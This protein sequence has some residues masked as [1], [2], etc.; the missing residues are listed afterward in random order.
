MNSDEISK[1]MAE[2]DELE[3]QS[4]REVRRQE[5]QVMYRQLAAQHP[6]P[7]PPP[8][9]VDEPP[10]D[11]PPMA[12]PPMDEQMEDPPVEDQPMDDGQM[13]RLQLTEDHL[14]LRRPGWRDGDDIGDKYWPIGEL[15]ELRQEALRGWW[16]RCQEPKRQ[17][18]FELF[19]R[20]HKRDVLCLGN[21]TISKNNSVSVWENGR[22][23]C[24][25]CRVD[26]NDKRP[27][28]RLV[29]LGTQR[30]DWID[31]LDRI[32]E[33]LPSSD[34]GAALNGTLAFHYWIPPPLPGIRGR[35]SKTQR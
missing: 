20:G 2:Y 35:K 8:P 5:R 22:C 25:S 9:P 31:G 30:S 17:K 21:F 1:L 27:C 23:A 16:Q 12:A 3:K 19:T 10:M 28:F 4:K 18:D 33:V 14:R 13:P 32:V 34:E 29:Y 24:P 11:A 15:S 26:A 6:L 7:P